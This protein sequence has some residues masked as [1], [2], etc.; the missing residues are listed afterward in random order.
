MATLTVFVYIL[1]AVLLA[2]AVWFLSF[3]FDDFV[4]P[5]RP[6]HACGVFIR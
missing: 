5:T 2:P 4:R 3:A 1:I 6:R